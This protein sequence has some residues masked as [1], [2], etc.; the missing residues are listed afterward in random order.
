MSKDTQSRQYQAGDTIIQQGDSADYVYT[1]T[2]GHAEAYQAGVKVGDIYAGEIFGALAAFTDSKRNA[3]VKAT[4]ACTVETVH[5]DNFLSLVEEQPQLC[6]KLIS[7]MARLIS[8][9]NESILLLSASL[10]EESGDEC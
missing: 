2:Q 3:T 8:D 5:K 7:D 4:K 10:E 9:L 1:L 6:V